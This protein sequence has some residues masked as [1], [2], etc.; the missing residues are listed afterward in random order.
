MKAKITDRSELNWATLTRHYTF[1][2]MTDDNEVVL[3]AQ[4]IESRPSEVVATLQT[5]V[6]EYQ[7]AYEE[8]N[9]V[10]VGTEV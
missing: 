2:V 9:D 3:T 10:E 6:A 1:D 8:A 5:K 4:S 7:A